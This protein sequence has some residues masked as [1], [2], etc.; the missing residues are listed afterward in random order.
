MRQ[1]CWGHFPRHWLQRTPL[2]SDPDMHHDTCITSGSLIRGRGESIPGN[3]R[4]CVT[5]NFMYLARAGKLIRLSNHKKHP[6][7]IS[8]AWLRYGHLWYFEEHW[9]CYTTVCIIVQMDF[10]TELM[11]NSSEK[12]I[13]YSLMVALHAVYY[14][15]SWWNSLILH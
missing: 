13:S 14:A 9:P 3:P 7:L 1:E 8:P 6:T 15:I 11:L 10:I 4:T 5:S 2:V 12:Y